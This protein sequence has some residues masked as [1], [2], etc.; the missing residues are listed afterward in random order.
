M[1]KGFGCCPAGVCVVFLLL[2][3]VAS[4][5]DVS[6]ADDAEQSIAED[7]A[8]AAQFE[9]DDGQCNPALPIFH[10]VMKFNEH[11]FI[12]S[13]LPQPTGV[14]MNELTSL[15]SC[16][17]WEQN[18]CCTD[19]YFGQLGKTSDQEAKRFQRVRDYYKF[20]VS[21]MVDPAI[22]ALDS[23]GEGGAAAKVT[24]VKTSLEE[25]PVRQTVN[26]FIDQCED[27]IRL[28]FGATLCELCDPHLASVILEERVLRVKDDTCTTLHD[29]CKDM[30]SRLSE[31]AEVFR[32]AAEKMKQ[33][34]RG[35]PADQGAKQVLG[36]MVTLKK[37][38]VAIGNVATKIN[39]YQDRTKLCSTLAAE[40]YTYRPSVWADLDTLHPGSLR[41]MPR[42]V[43][44][45]SDDVQFGDTSMRTMQDQLRA[46][47]E[48]EAKGAGLSAPPL[49]QRKFGVLAPTL[50]EN[51][52]LVKS[53]AGSECQCSP[54]WTGN[55]CE[56]PVHY[57]AAAKQKFRPMSSEPQAQP[58]SLH[59]MGCNMFD[60]ERPLQ[61]L[62]GHI[63]FVRSGP[64]KKA[65]KERLLAAGQ[66]SKDV[67]LVRGSASGFEKLL[68]QVPISTFSDHLEWLVHVPEIVR[69]AAKRYTVCFC[70]GP[71]CLEEL[72]QLSAMGVNR[73]F[74][75]KDALSWYTAGHVGVHRS[76]E[77]RYNNVQYGVGDGYWY[78]PHIEQSKNPCGEQWAFGDLTN[79]G[80]TARKVQGDMVTF[81]C[82]QGFID[83]VGP[84]WL[85]CIDATWFEEPEQDV[86]TPETDALEAWNHDLPYCRWETDSCQAPAAKM[87]GGSVTVMGG[88]ARYA[89]EADKHLVIDGKLVQ[90]ASF[91]RWCT[92]TGW[93]PYQV[94]SCQ[95]WWGK[96]EALPT[97]NQIM[98]D[99]VIPP[100][101]I[102]LGSKEESE[103]EDD[104]HA[105][106]SMPAS[107]E[108]A[109]NASLAAA[110]S[111]FV[112]LG[113]GAQQ[114][115][116][117]SAKTSRDG[118]ETSSRGRAKVESD[119]L[120]QATASSKVSHA[121]SVIAPGTLQVHPWRIQFTKDATHHFRVDNCWITW[122]CA[123]GQ[124]P[125]DAAA[126]P[127]YAYS[128]P[129]EESHLPGSLALAAVA[130]IVV[131]L[132]IMAV[133]TKAKG[134]RSE[135]T[136]CTDC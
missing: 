121:A 86:K 130:S 33:A 101:L 42:P 37:V 7:S 125:D 99:I 25:S 44:D 31:A 84:R 19:K 91:V 52:K 80:I 129:L 1:H 131:S 111:S 105:A 112:E 58:Q 92:K 17:K 133:V 47:Q 73:K 51:G 79:A 49:P 135:C 87:E 132:A 4:E 95:P 53:P 18:S 68:T 29:K 11:D 22:A 102:Q 9:T 34:N 94:P 107:S 55:K 56:V 134:A 12:R 60:A 8:A 66:N 114:T 40:G 67:C 36:A 97:T 39:F 59:I 50:C 26:D 98:S 106:A 104:E 32:D 69:P 57:R 41:S 48:K 46:I 103:E 76:D 10:M 81:A 6:L 65:E 64:L 23:S 20:A 2:Q 128:P 78:A 117:S 5:R 71:E 83:L 45:D 72:Q 123:D 62:M 122:A 88:M 54:C 116:R 85:R 118:V 70:Y 100:S 35:V 28:F 124:I 89:C 82:A 21:D 3:L 77:N 136:G 61:S 108:A 16:A 24:E 115:Q 93:L 74:Q 75:E 14:P 30:P 110:S 120:A 90:A 109:A 119:D 38:S 27:S 96:V 126:S 63:K 113:A 43:A 127:L 13:G 15:Q